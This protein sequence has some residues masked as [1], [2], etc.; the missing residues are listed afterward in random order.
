[1]PRPGAYRAPYPP[2]VTANDLGEVEQRL[3]DATPDDPAHGVGWKTFASAVESV[4]SGDVAPLH[5]LY[6]IFAILAKSPL[7]PARE[8]G[9]G[10]PPR[11]AYH[12]SIDPLAAP[13]YPPRS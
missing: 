13:A 10:S 5:D 11:D 6:N 2:P 1:M 12:T 9:G 3:V 7:V 4:R 8:V